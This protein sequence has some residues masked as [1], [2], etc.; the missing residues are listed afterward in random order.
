MIATFMFYE[1]DWRRQYRS[2]CLSAV[3]LQ[4]SIREGFGLVVSEAMW[5][6][7]PVVAGRAGGIPLQLQNGVEGFLVDSVEQCAEKSLWLLQSS[8]EGHAVAAKGRELVS[9]AL[10]AAATN[11]R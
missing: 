3:V 7:T 10:F 11:R 9:P 8:N 6:G 4:K 1:P 5:K 2:E